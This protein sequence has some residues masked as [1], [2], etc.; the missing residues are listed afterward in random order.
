MSQQF[1]DNCA[2]SFVVIKNY[3]CF[4][5]FLFQKLYF[6]RKV[7]AKEQQQLT[8][9]FSIEESTFE[10]YPHSYVHFYPGNP[11]LKVFINLFP[12]TYQRLYSFHKQGHLHKLL[13]ALE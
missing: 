4:F 3:T 9:A 8:K 1:N 12:H 10:L 11:A 2:G 7:A 13:L 6:C 5:F